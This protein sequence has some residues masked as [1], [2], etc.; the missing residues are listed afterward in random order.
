MVNFDN[1][2][3]AALASPPQRVSPEPI[4]KSDDGKRPDFPCCVRSAFTDMPSSIPRRPA[5]ATRSWDGLFQ[6]F[7]SIQRRRPSPNRGWVGYHI[8]LFEA[9]STF[10]GCYGLS[11]RCI[12]IVQMRFGD[13]PDRCEPRAVK[14]RPNPCHLLTIPRADT[15]SRIEAGEILYPHIKY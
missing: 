10:T 13:R 14:R 1:G 11:A 12:L 3:R 2:H 9:C 7:P 6:P 4:T 5:G 8:G 15:K